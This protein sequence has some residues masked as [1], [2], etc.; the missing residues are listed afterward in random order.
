MKK[1]I[2]VFF[3]FF[4]VCYIQGIAESSIPLIPT[5][6]LVFDQLL[7]LLQNDSCFRE[8]SKDLARICSAHEE[9]L[10]EVSLD[11]CLSGS[12]LIESATPYYV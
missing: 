4:L 2:C 7:L 10:V 11:L 1:R 9:E 5:L 6:S 12:S 8:V 3:S